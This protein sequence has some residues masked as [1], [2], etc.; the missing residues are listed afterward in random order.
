[1]DVLSFI[2][3]ICGIISFGV[4]LVLWFKFDRIKNE[5]E[6]QRIDYEKTRKTVLSKL[7]ALNINIVED[8]LITPK[9]INDLRIELNA[10]K[11]KFSRLLSWEDKKHLKAT[12]NLLNAEIKNLDINTISL[13]LAYFIA[14]FRKKEIKNG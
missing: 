6:Q 1:M 12:F 9:I 13:E 11:L 10:F 5:I 14:R 8:K 7:N 2:A 3:D 4:S